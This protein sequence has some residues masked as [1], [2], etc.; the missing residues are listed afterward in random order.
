VYDIVGDLVDIG[1]DILNP[2]QRS[3]AGMDIV[4]LKKE[5]GQDLTFWG[6]GIDIQQVLPF[7][8][9]EEIRD[10]VKRTFEIMAPGGGFV[11]FPSHNVQADVTPDR[12]HAA[13]DAALN[14]RDY[15]VAAG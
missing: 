7:A 15:P 6:G 8:S 3:A 12:F 10:D 11:F 2:I 14:H 1:V 5:F 9:L 4:K 13:F